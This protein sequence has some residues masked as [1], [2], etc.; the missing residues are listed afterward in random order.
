MSDKMNERIEELLKMLGD[1]D[2]FN[3]EI[4]EKGSVK[5]EKEGEMKKEEKKSEVKKVMSPRE[6]VER[7][8]ETVIGQDEVK[9]SLAVAFFKYLTER[10]NADKLKELAEDMFSQVCLKTF[11]EIKTENE[12]EWMEDPLFDQYEWD[13]IHEFKVELISFYGD[14]TP[15]V[16]L[17]KVIKE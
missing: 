3:R 14:E 4:I 16:L 11:L 5:V 1:V 17:S 7:L 15:Q 10:L 13:S 9:K 12:G 6:I 2:D 8:N